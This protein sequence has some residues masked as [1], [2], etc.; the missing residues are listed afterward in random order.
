MAD[1][2]QR[3]LPIGSLDAME[4]G[5][6]RGW[7]WD[8][9]SP[10]RPTRIGVF[11]DGESL[12][13]IQPQEF[14]GDLAQAGIGHGC[15]AFTLRLPDYLRD[16][17]AH[18]VS[19]RH[20]GI[21]PNTELPNSPVTFTLQPPELAAPS[22]LLTNGDFAQVSGGLFGAVPAGTI[23]EVGPGLA[24]EAGKKDVLWSLAEPRWPG[25]DAPPYYGLR[26][27][28]EGAGEARLRMVLAPVRQ[29]ARAV[30]PLA[31]EAGLAAAPEPV[32]QRMAELWLAQ[33]GREGWR[34]LRRLHRG[35][36]FRRQALLGFDL[37]LTPEE[38]R[39]RRAGA[40]AF[41]VRVPGATAW[42]A[43]PP[44]S[45]RT[46][47]PRPGGFRGMEDPGLE[48]AFAACRPLAAA[49]G[50][51]AEFDALLRPPAAGASP[52]PPQAARLN[53]LRYPYVQVI[54]PL[55]N[56]GA[57]I[58]DCLRSVR[59]ATDTPFGC[60]VV[61]DGSRAY[62][63][64]QVE[65]IVAGDPR[66]T[67]LPHEANRGYTKAINA[68][69]MATGAD[70]V[71]ILNSDTLVPRGW[72]ARLLDA[73]ASRDAV[74]M[75]GPLSNAASW[76]SIPAAKEADLTWSRNSAIRP[77]HLE[78]VQAILDAES[79]RAYPEVPLLNGFCTL[80]SRAVFETCGL[81]DEDAFPIGYGE[82][83]DLNIRAGK[84]GFKL[85][86]ADDLFVFHHKSVSFGT[87]GRQP[88]AK[89]GF[90]EMTNKHLGTPVA[91]LEQRLQ[92]EPAL[93]RLRQRLADLPARLG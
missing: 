3:T 40:L 15:Y 78:R 38:E 36:L 19:L 26:L 42:T 57:P 46:A 34:D 23:A 52:A 92:T 58:F 48:A 74:G 44:R 87:E 85:V 61:D 59:D 29:G 20:L 67:L 60:L 72:L 77:E 28:G 47:P 21:G 86:I 37:R 75:V 51:A 89:Q 1:T 93:M 8:E 91:A 18:S 25:G 43:Y 76:Q 62:T 65:E 79:E 17:Q 83:T 81:F 7:A 80:I 55:M 35:R 12:T 27:A 24:I 66:F 16:G 11:L 31:F 50:R 71:V 45:L 82:E 13:T 84:A 32:A 88:L 2:V 5:V 90:L 63:A 64:G 6:L 56:G 10:Q 14:R 30:I 41:S 69:V 49:L 54:V 73:A 39:A 68:A 4:D 33:E 53:L 70:W 22:T 9:A